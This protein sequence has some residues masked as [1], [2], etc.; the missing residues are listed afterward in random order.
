MDWPRAVHTGVSE[1]DQPAWGEIATQQRAEVLPGKTRAHQGGGAVPWKNTH[2][3]SPRGITTHGHLAQHRVD[4]GQ[5][6]S[7]GPGV[8][9][10]ATPD[11]RG[12]GRNFNRVRRGEL[13]WEATRRT[14]PVRR[15]EWRSKRDWH[16]AGSSVT[17]HRDKYTG[18]HWLYTEIVKPRKRI[19]CRPA[20]SF[21]NV[22]YW[23]ASCQSP[24]G[25]NASRRVCSHPR[26]HGKR[27]AW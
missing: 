2:V 21:T 13:N 27:R 6:T 20:G 7:T 15:G 4:L 19:R 23:G 11:C 12:C 16:R 10:S 14:Y 25:S 17:G 26:G 1:V 9:C 18:G 22:C 24:R 8:W 5:R 3:G